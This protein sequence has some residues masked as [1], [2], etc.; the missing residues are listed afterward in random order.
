MAVDPDDIDVAIT[1][2]LNATEIETSPDTNR[3]KRSDALTLLQVRA[4]LGPSADLASGKRRS[5]KVCFGGP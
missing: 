5:R 1:K 3:I 4:V 2:S